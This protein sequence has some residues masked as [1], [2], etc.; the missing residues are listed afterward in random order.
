MALQLVGRRLGPKG[1]V[2]SSMKTLHKCW[3]SE[4]AGSPAIQIYVEDSHTEADARG[5]GIVYRVS[6][7][8]SQ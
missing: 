1:S 6:A 7:L 5:D 8:G 3:V 4:R 2:W